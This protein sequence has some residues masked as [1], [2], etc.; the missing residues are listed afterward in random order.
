[1]RKF[2]LIGAVLVLT[3]ALSGGYLVYI[4][5]RPTQESPSSADLLTEKERTDLSRSLANLLWANLN[6]YSPY[7]DIRAVLG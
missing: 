7:Y 4:K 5:P 6:H 1:M 2:Y 3:L